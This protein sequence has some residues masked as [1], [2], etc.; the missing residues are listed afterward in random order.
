MARLFLGN[1]N[2]EKS[3]NAK[4]N[5]LLI[6]LPLIGL[7]LFSISSGWIDFWPLSLGELIKADLEKMHYIENY[8]IIHEKAILL[9]VSLH[10]YFMVKDRIKI[11]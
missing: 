2:S 11:N 6:L 8:K 4:E 3:S 5:S 1:S 9:G 7:A 10:F